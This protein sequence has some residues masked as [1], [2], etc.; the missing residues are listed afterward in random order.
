MVKV[1]DVCAI[2]GNNYAN[3]KK[4]TDIMNHNHPK[5]NTVKHIDNLH[6]LIRYCCKQ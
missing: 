6:Y 2:T 3:K 5:C 1:R 4:Y